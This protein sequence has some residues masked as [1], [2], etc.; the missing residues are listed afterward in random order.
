MNSKHYTHRS[1]KIIKTFQVSYYVYIQCCNVQIVTKGKIN[2][3]K[4]GLNLQWCLFFTYLAAVMAHCGISPSRYGS[5][6]K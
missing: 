1:S 5:F 3:H 6:S 2:K 4:Y